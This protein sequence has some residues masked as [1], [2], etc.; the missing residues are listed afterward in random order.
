VC[1]ARDLIPELAGWARSERCAGSPAHGWCGS[2]IAASGSPTCPSFVQFEDE[3]QAEVC[4]QKFDELPTTWNTA[5][6]T[7]TPTA[8]VTWPLAWRRNAHPTLS[9]I[10][11]DVLT[12]VAGTEHLFTTRQVRPAPEEAAATHSTWLTGESGSRPVRPGSTSSTPGRERPQQRTPSER[13]SPPAI[14]SCEVR[15]A[16][17]N[18]GPDR[19]QPGRRSSRSS[20]VPRRSGG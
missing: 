8:W 20:R 1:L 4:W 17:A 9:A 3:H 6:V 7:V 5:D 15:R 12:D 18:I 16:F 14:G 13:R 19:I 2:P 10:G 11:G